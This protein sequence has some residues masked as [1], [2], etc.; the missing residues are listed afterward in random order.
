MDNM[1]DR[2]SM[3]FFLS[4]VFFIGI[5]VCIFFAIDYCLSYFVIIPLILLDFVTLFVAYQSLTYRLTLR[6]KFEVVVDE[7]INIEEEMN[8]RLDERKKTNKLLDKMLKY[9]LYGS[10]FIIALSIFFGIFVVDRQLVV[11]ECMS[12]LY[13]YI[14]SCFIL[15]KRYLSRFRYH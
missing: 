1:K 9:S 12:F 2:Y 14:F 3:R 6:K 10:P 8:K 11:V 4:T 15:R 5:F 13:S 7:K